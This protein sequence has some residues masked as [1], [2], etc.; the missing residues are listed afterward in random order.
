MPLLLGSRRVDVDISSYDD[1]R[2]AV[3]GTR[4]MSPSLRA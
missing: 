3:T 1:V 4:V 2:L